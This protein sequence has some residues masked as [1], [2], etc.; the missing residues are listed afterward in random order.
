[1]KQGDL[2][3][4]YHCL[5]T[6]SE[7]NNDSF[8]TVSGDSEIISYVHIRLNTLPHF[9]LDFLVINILFVFSRFFVTKNIFSNLHYFYKRRFP[10]T[11]TFSRNMNCGIN[12]I[13]FESFKPSMANVQLQAL[14]HVQNKF[15]RESLVLG[16]HRKV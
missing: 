4:H 1:L 16:G 11:F 8:L 7:F 10:M 13:S 12:D 14:Q 2:I 9:I 15:G 5:I 6:I 3:I